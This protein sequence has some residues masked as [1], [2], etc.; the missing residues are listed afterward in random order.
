MRLFIDSDII[1]DLLTERVPHFKSAAQLFL[2]IQT[3]KHEA[4][5]SAIVFVNLHYILRKQLG[6][7]KTLTLLRK[8]KLLIT[9]LPTS[10]KAIENSL[11]SNFR[12]YEDSV[13]YYTALEHSIDALIT[14]NKKDYKDATILV[15]SAT[16]F[17]SL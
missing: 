14:R 11:N 17:L 3:G 6:K 7:E 12:D 10:D 4:Y 9:I 1:L 15:T 2:S 13:Q 5:S 8:L 16:E